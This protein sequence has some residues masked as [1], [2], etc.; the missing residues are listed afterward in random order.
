MTETTEPIDERPTPGPGH[1]KL[2]VLIGTWRSEGHTVAGPDDPG[3]VIVGT[4]DYQWLGGGFFVV[5]RIDVR[6]GDEHV[7]AI[8]IIGNDRATGAY[9]THAFDH[10][11]GVATYEM[12]ERDGTWTVAGDGQRSRLEVAGDGV[13]MAAHWERQ[14]ADGSWVPWMEMAFTKIA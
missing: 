14:E 2:E 5:H 13:T 7:E 3:T 9:P 8:E 1:A 11:G 10:T 6:M 4:D 12:T